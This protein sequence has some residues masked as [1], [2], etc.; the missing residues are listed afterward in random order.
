[1]TDSKSGSMKAIRVSQFG[2]PEVLQL[3]EVPDLVPTG[4]QV[5]VRLEAI[6]VNPVDTYLRSGK[7]PKLPELPYTPGSDGAGTNVKTGERVYLSRSLT[8][9]Y[10]ELC[11]ASPEQVHPLPD[12]CSFQDGAALGVPASTAYHALF[13]KG[14]IKAGQRVLIRGASGAVGLAAVQLAKG[15]GCWVAG[16]ASTPEGQQ[17]V[18][19]QG[20]DEVSGHDE[21]EGK[22]DVI[23]E[24]L[25]NSGLQRDLEQTSPRGTIVIV[26]NRGEISIDPRLTMTGDLTVKGMSLANATAEELKDI[27][28]GLSEALKK[29]VLRPVIRRTYPLAQASQ[30]HIDVLSPG[31][32]GK[33]LLVTFAHS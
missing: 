20:A 12:N 13:H 10:A 2:G 22:Y 31:A 27:H 29:G 26:G 11:L 3:V 4:D 8:G 25:A 18:K 23:L 5:L 9:T 1:M 15:H 32:A 28:Q 7:Y 17:L 14:V 16:T 24:M 6:G 21:T 30:A 19:E 33:L